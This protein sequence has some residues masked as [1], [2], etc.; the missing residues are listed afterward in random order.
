[1]F[2]PF[3]FTFFFS[4][5][6]TSMQPPQNG[7]ADPKQTQLSAETPKP[8]SAPLSAPVLKVTTRIVVV[9]T[10]VSNKSGKPILGLKAEDFEVLEDGKPQEIRNF[11]LRT[12]PAESTGPSSSLAPPLPPGVFT[13]IPQLA[14]DGGPPTLLLID[15]RNTSQ[16]DQPYMRQQLIDY[17]RSIHGRRNIAI[18]SL[19][20]SL[21]LLYDFNSDP[22]VLQE[23]LNGL[24]GHSTE[25]LSPEAKALSAELSGETKLSYRDNLEFIREDQISAFAPEGASD[26]LDAQIRYTLAALTRLARHVAGYP[27]R[28]SLVWLTSAFP[29]AV[30]PSTSHPGDARNYQEEIRKAAN[31]MTDSEV[32]VYPVDARG[33]TGDLLPDPADRAAFPGLIGGSRLNDFI[34]ARV[35]ESGSTKS[36]MDFFAAQT[37][38][39]AFYNRNDIDEGIRRSVQDGAAYYT[40]SY[41]PANKNWDGKFRKIQVKVRGSGLRVHYRH[42]YFATDRAPQSPALQEWS[43][44]EF[45]SSLALNAPTATLLP[46]VARVTPPSSEHGNAVVDVGI[47]PKA[48]L[49]ETGNDNRH[50]A[51]LKLATSIFKKDGALL[52]TKVVDLTTALRTET[53]NKVMQTQVPIRQS[54]NLPP[55]SYTLKIGVWDQESGLT[56]TVKANVVVPGA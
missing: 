35:I 47:D 19:G 32:S 12:T 25:K 14:L 17:L 45:L 42:G 1:V 9:D 21:R 8:V 18:Y 44:K 13:N 2:L 7:P 43:K 26:Q 23:A 3:F 16:A 33:L 27:G 4:A 52:T 22:R 30:P 51:R 48:V 49:F 36:A 6:G 34:Q 38:G 50:H 41:S 24:S 10:V 31:V 40:L 55:G 15:L 29:L 54:L 20:S 37:G 28:K 56:G 5:S 53:F 46:F 11:G 39:E